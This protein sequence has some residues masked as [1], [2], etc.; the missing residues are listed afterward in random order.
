MIVCG[1]EDVREHKPA[2]SGKNPVHPVHRCESKI[3]PCLT[4][5]RFPATRRRRLF[6]GSPAPALPC[7]SFESETGFVSGKSG[8]R[9][10]RRGG[11]FESETGFVSDKLLMT[12]LHYLKDCAEINKML[13]ASI[14]SLATSHWPLSTIHLATPPPPTTIRIIQGETGVFQASRAP[15]PQDGADHS[16]VK[17]VLF[18]ASGQ[19][20]PHPAVRIIPGKTDDH[21]K[22]RTT[23]G[24]E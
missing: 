2:V 13:N 10:P 18:Q 15:A 17:Q 3:Y 14:K 7:G 9:P 11:S 1:F 21:Q 4:M 6:Q 23:N 19:P 20:P 24:H 16:R 12:W 5:N 8:P 22:R